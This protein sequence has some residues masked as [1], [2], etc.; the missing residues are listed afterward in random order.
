MTVDSPFVS[1]DTVDPKD[2]NDDAEIAAENQHDDLEIDNLP[3]RL[4]FLRV[5]LVPV[6]IWGLMTDVPWKNQI[7]F[8][9]F[10]IAAITDY[11]DGYYARARK[12][13]TIM[14]QLLDPLADKL[15]I[16]SSLA[17]LQHLGRI[18][19]IVVIVLLSREFAITGLRAV[20]SAEGI[21]IAASGL[22]KWKTVAQMIGIPALMLGSGIPF[23]N[24]WFP[25]LLVGD[26][27]IYGSLFIS[28]WSG[29]DYVVDFFR[30]M[31]RHRRQRREARQLARQKKLQSKGIL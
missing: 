9:V 1:K 31:A 7:A 24:K 2:Q 8:W 21:V 4:T 13:I 27:F 18:H 20:A 11:F 23:M 12:I 25:P 16:L 14:G 15:L 17:M 26:I 29:K 28:V 5:L 10:V 22:A 19:P 3:N 6:V 30:A